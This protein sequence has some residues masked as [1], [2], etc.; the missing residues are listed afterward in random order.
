[1]NQ[2]EEARALL[3]AAKVD[4]PL[5]SIPLPLTDA[6]QKRMVI[7][8]DDISDDESVDTIDDPV[9][10]LPVQGVLPVMSPDAPVTPTAKSSKSDKPERTAE[11]QLKLKKRAEAARARRAE[12]KRLENASASAPSVP[13]KVAPS[14]PPTKGVTPMPE[15]PRKKKRTSSDAFSDSS[16]QIDR[17]TLLNKLIKKRF[18]GKSGKAEDAASFMRL[19]NETHCIGEAILALQTVKEQMVHELQMGATKI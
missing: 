10:A 3:N 4:I 8:D 9:V 15:A 5:A 7:D 13:Q 19:V 18:V 16:D 1:M 12:K 14:T 11:E 17:I 6:S 2:L